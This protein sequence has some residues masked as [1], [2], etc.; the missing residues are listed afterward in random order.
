LNREGF[1]VDC[2]FIGFT[3]IT[4]TDNGRENQ[5][6]REL[7]KRKEPLLYFEA[8][9][10]NSRKETSSKFSPRKGNLN[11]SEEACRHPRRAPL[12]TRAPARRL[13]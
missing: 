5:V 13:T 10:N 1:A 11:P 8:H 3:R 7:F 12:R 4:K 2:K 6:E 9:V